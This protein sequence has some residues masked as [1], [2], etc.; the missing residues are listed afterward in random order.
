[1]LSEM[2]KHSEYLKWHMNL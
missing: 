1:M 2:Q